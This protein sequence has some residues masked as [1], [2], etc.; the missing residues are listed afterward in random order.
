M[1]MST[2]WS[3]MAKECQKSPELEEARNR[4]HPRTFRE[5]VHRPP[6]RFWHS[7]I[8][9]GLLDSRTVKE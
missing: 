4:L 2:D 7:E 1:T 9:F 3:D 5:S 8:D 6:S